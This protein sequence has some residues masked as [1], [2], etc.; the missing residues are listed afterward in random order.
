MRKLFSD[1]RD[2]DGWWRHVVVE[3]F[4]QQLESAKSKASKEKMDSAYTVLVEQVQDTVESEEANMIDQFLCQHVPE[5]QTSRQRHRMAK[6]FYNT[7]NDWD[8]N[9]FTPTKEAIDKL[10]EAKRADMRQRFKQLSEP[11]AEKPK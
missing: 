2:D 9:T 1:N 11:K 6:R 10:P 7:G 8:R 3:A 4:L 5:Y